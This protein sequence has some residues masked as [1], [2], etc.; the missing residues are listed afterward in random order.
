M[1]AVYTHHVHTHNTTSIGCNANIGQ[2]FVIEEVREG[3][4]R[5]S[6]QNIRFDSM[7]QCSE[8]CVKSSVKLDMSAVPASHLQCDTGLTWDPSAKLC[9]QCPTPTQVRAVLP[10]SPWIEWGQGGPCHPGGDGST[11]PTTTQACTK[12][13][14]LDGKCGTVITIQYYSGKCPRNIKKNQRFYPVG[15]LHTLLSMN[16]SNGQTP[17][18]VRYCMDPKFVKIWQDTTIANAR[19][20]GWGWNHWLVGTNNNKVCPIPSTYIY[21]NAIGTYPADGGVSN[22]QQVNAKLIANDIGCEYHDGTFAELGECG[23]WWSEFSSDTIYVCVNYVSPAY[24]PS[25]RSA[26]GTVGL[27]TTPYQI[28]WDDINFAYPQSGYQYWINTNLGNYNFSGYTRIPPTICEAP[29]TS[30]NWGC[31]YKTPQGFCFYKIDTYQGCSNGYKPIYCGN[32]GCTCECDLNYWGTIVNTPVRTVGTDSNAW[33]NG[34]YFVSSG[35]AYCTSNGMQPWIDWAPRDGN[36]VYPAQPCLRAHDN[37][38]DCQA[39]VFGHCQI[40]SAHSNVWMGSHWSGDTK[41]HF[42]ECSEYVSQVGC[43]GAYN[44]YNDWGIYTGDASW[45]MP[46]TGANVAGSCDNANVFACGIHCTEYQTHCRTATSQSECASTTNSGSPCVWVPPQH[47]ISPCEWVPS[48]VARRPC[49]WGIN[50]DGENTISRP[51]EADGCYQP[52]LETRF[53]DGNNTFACGAGQQNN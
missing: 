42:N 9:V 46:G 32:M 45:R 47:F 48:T 31:N 23:T 19:A 17:D 8:M 22:P 1:T 35:S 34:N 37:Q 5:S 10:S 38:R 18:D 53:Q 40:N 43:E 15:N 3:K 11:G 44:G 49:N 4:G 27:V 16:E 51:C 28:K 6:L 50:G 24:M 29:N 39:P 41:Y 12:Q 21:S 33:V 2:C 7:Q 25:I 14:L 30:N 52:C 13:Q 26:V 36:Y 20:G